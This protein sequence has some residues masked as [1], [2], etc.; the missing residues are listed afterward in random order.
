MKKLIILLSL[1]SLLYLTSC[2]S[3]PTQ[4]RKD[5]FNII[6]NGFNSIKKTPSL[7][8]VIELKNVKIHI[9]GNRKLFDYKKAKLRNSG[10]AGYSNTKNEIWLFGKVVKGKII[11][12]QVILGHELNHLLQ[13]KNKQ[14]ANPDKLDKLGV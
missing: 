14:I 6:Q 9:V 3:L 4:A 7:N 8:K 13:F 2:V 12:N 1:L 10:I 5:G 11:I